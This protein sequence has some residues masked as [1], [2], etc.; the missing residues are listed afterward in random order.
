MHNIIYI[1]TYVLDYHK[2]N[3]IIIAITVLVVITVIIIIIVNNDYYTY[4]GF[5]FCEP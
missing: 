3:L 2:Y 4:M 5:Q 1:Y